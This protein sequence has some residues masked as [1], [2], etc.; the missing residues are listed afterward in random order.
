M[1]PVEASAELQEPRAPGAGLDQATR[2]AAARLSGGLSPWSIYLAWLDWAAHLAASP[3]KQ[4]Q[5]AAKAARKLNRLA[6]YARGLGQAGQAPAPCIE[7]LP[8]D[9][10]F[11]DPAWQRWPH[12]LIEQSFLLLQQWWYNAT[13]GVR[14]VSRHHE[15]LVTFLARQW[16]DV[17]SP[18]N[19]VL[20]NPE[21]LQRTVQTGGM[22]LVQGFANF[23]EDAERFAAGRPAAGMERYVPGETVAATPGKVVFRNALVEMIQ[24]APATAQTLPEPV[25]IVPSWIMKYYILDLSPE[26][27]LVRYLVGQGRTVFMLSWRNPGAADRDLGLEEYLDAIG[28]ALRAAGA[29]VPGAG[30]HLAGYCLGGTMAAITAALA[31]DGDRPRLASLTLFAAELD[32]EEPGELSLFVDES[33]VSMLED[34]MAEQGFLDG[35]Q[36]AGAFMMLNSRDLLWS[37]RTHEYL[38]G[39]RAAP[40]DLMAWNADATRLPARM[41]SQFLRGF[42][43]DNDL[44]EGRF[45]V[46]GRAVALRDIAVPVFVVATEWDHISPWRSVFKAHLL[47]DSELTFALTNG[48]HNAGIVSQPGHP[49]RHYRIATRPPRA[50]YAAPDD[51]LDRAE[52][53]EGSWWPAWSAWLAARSGAPAAPPGMG[54][55]LADAPGRYVLIP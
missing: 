41:H 45:R 20:A 1:I 10:R 3:G 31:R 49:G 53:R 34:L 22:N 13:T 50:P 47:V 51:W 19:F 8:Q 29:I 9:G 35:K 27:S 36:L 43:L 44:A 7:P 11:R 5:L 39:E 23:I 54:P 2:A 4:A 16:L 30:V 25:L 28:A 12:N 18:S 42:Y 32:Y 37:R 21:V 15:E 6:V 46:R 14:G 55:A 26:N 40:S 48:G 17:L 52:S 38:L 33:Q 24:Y